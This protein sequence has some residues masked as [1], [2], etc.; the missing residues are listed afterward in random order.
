M[1]ALSQLLSWRWI[2]L[3]HTWPGNPDSFKKYPFFFS[4]TIPHQF[5]RDSAT[6]FL[7]GAMQ[8]QYIFDFLPIQNLCCNSYDE[9]CIGGIPPWHKTKM[10]ITNWGVILILLSLNLF[11]AFIVCSSYYASVGVTF[12]NI[13]FVLVYSQKCTC[14]PFILESLPFPRHH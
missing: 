10:I 1:A 13:T 11:L 2:H 14:S 5:S 8:T 4:K 7:S 6:S 9:N 12:L 3:P